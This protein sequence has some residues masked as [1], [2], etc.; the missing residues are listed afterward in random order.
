MF[1]LIAFW[2][3]I[4][5]ISY[6]RLIKP[7]ATLFRT[8]YTKCGEG[9]ETRKI[10]IPTILFMSYEWSCFNRSTDGFF[11][12][13]FFY[14]KNLKFPWSVFFQGLANGVF[15]LKL[16][17]CSF[18][19]RL[20]FNCRDSSSSPVMVNQLL[21]TVPRSESFSEHETVDGDLL[22]TN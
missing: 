18:W 20:F 8:E 1:V 9:E 17:P 11:G 3:L 15:F 6:T 14:N 2:V 4:Y 22:L 19:K 7:Y 13:F 10:W 16:I 5:D 21:Y 12:D